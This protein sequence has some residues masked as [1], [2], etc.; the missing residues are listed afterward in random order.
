VKV[1]D[2]RGLTRRELTECCLAFGLAGGRRC[3]G[4][5]HWER[6]GHCDSRIRQRGAR[7]AERGRPLIGTDIR[8][9]SGPGRRASTA[10]P[11]G[12]SFERY[13][14]RFSQHQG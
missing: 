2:R 5:D 12:K 14:I 4:L 9:A 7:K 11:L 10:P 1:N 13:A 6:Q 3:L 8:G